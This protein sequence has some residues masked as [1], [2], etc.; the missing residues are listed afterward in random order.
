M[1]RRPLIERLDEILEE[2]NAARAEFR[3]DLEARHR[4]WS[5]EL[6]ERHGDLRHLLLNE[7]Q[8]TREMLLELR[9]GREILADIQHGIRAN[10]EGLLRILDELRR[11]DGPGTAKA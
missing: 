11:E 1:A 4:R 9:R 2:Q 10:T 3:A 6:D 8:V 5:R 7:R